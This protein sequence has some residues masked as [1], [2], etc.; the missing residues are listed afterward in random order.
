[1]DNNLIYVIGGSG[2]MGTT[3]LNLLKLNKLNAI[4]INKNDKLIFDKKLKLLIDFSTGKNSVQTALWCKQNNI[5]LIIGATG[6]TKEE[7]HI[8]NNCKN[9]IPIMICSNFSIGIYFV[10]QLLLK[11]KHLNID[12]III[13]EK[14]HKQKID[15]PSGTAITLKNFI[16][17]NLAKDV[18]I[19]AERGGNEIGTHTIDLYFKNELITISH[20][21][22][23]RESFADG[24]I[25]ATKFMLKNKNNGLFTFES[26]LDKVY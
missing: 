19:L 10:K 21:A 22:F 7:L 25:L 15:S 3:V 20:K 9:T 13:F 12:D 6:Q 23:S 16:N 1:M 17:N 18:T 4:A 2:K 24:V 14:H 5:P 11:L 8:I 26:V